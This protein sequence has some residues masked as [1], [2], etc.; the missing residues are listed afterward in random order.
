MAVIRYCHVLRVMLLFPVSWLM[1]GSEVSFAS[2]FSHVATSWFSLW[3]L[4]VLRISLFSSNGGMFSSPNILLHHLTVV[5]SLG[6]SVELIFFIIFL[7]VS[8]MTNSFY[9]GLSVIMYLL[10]GSCQDAYTFL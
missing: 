2:A 10:T 7:F 1:I 9:M 4:V 6:G 8:F 3:I 5:I